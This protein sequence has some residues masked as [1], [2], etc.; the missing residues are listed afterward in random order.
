MKKIM[1]LNLVFFLGGIIGLL[2]VRSTT[3][4]ATMHDFQTNLGI[5][6]KESVNGI[7]LEDGESLADNVHHFIS[8]DGAYYVVNKEN[9]KTVEVRTWYQFRNAINDQN[10]SAINVSASFNTTFHSLDTI[11]R[12]LTIN[13]INAARIDLENNH[14]LKLA[15]HSTL[16]I[17]A[18]AKSPIFVS[19][20]QLK[21]PFIQS[22]YGS[23]IRL[24]GE[25]IIGDGSTELREQ[26]FIRTEG[27]I[28]VPSGS[29]VRIHE[30]IE[31]NDLFVINYGRLE[32]RAHEVTPIK[33]GINGTIRVGEFSSLKVTHGGSHS[34]IKMTGGE[35]FFDNPY[36]IH[37][38]QTG[39]GGLVAPLIDSSAV[40]M[41]INAVRNAFWENYNMSFRPTHVWNSQLQTRL[42]GPHGSQVLRSNSVSFE[43]HFLGFGSYR[44]YTAGMEMP[45]FPDTF[46]E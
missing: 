32:L 28:E 26:P 45:L 42:G 4:E 23:T 41:E 22:S 35:I 40:L 29:N 3:S 9:R 38:K 21:Q 24:E 31:A 44:E 13:F 2:F 10:V 43:K 46:P 7:L 20:N 11:D 25:V 36:S 17:K 15:K 14:A 34:V 6:V 18:N 5:G 1:Q 30:A 33:M 12:P 27:L 8:E 19:Q 37:L 16:E 39:F